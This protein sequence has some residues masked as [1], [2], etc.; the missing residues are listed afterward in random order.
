[1]M[2]TGVTC[3]TFRTVNELEAQLDYERIRREKLEAQLDEYRREITYLSNELD[4]FQLR[5]VSAVIY[6]AC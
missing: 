3:V 5:H 4:K 2:L 1:M 6:L